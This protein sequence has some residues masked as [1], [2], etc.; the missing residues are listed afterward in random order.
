MEKKFVNE[1]DYLIFLLLKHYNVHT[2]SELAKILNIT[3]QTISSWKSRNS[4]RAI[5]KILIKNN[6]VDAI[7]KQYD[8]NIQFLKK[9]RGI[10]A[11]NNFG[12]QIQNTAN[13]PDAEILA[14][15]EIAE[16]IYGKDEAKKNSFKNHIKSW[17]KE[18]I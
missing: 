8:S 16:K 5:Q 12:S 1:A 9:N 15:V 13:G 2:I 10:N 6:I 18:N 17:I 3:Q 4:V 7:E 11:L 14:I